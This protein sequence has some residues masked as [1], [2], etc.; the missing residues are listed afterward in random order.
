MKNYNLIFQ[1]ILH[2]NL[3]MGCCCPKLPFIVNE[4]ALVVVRNKEGKWLVVN[5]TKGRGWSLPGGHVDPPEAARVSATREVLEE[6]GIEVKITGILREEY[7]NYRCLFQKRRTIFYAEPVD[8]TQQPKTNSDEHSICAKWVTLDELLQLR[9]G[10]PGWRRPDLYYWGKYI[11]EGG[12]IY[13]L[14]PR[15]EIGAQVVI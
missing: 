14:P 11:E 15:E 6:A 4:T 12:T 3:Y 8:D 9:E 2:S 5:E 1:I 13:P 10:K 7:K